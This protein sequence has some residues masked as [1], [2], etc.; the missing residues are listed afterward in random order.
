MF[1][2]LQHFSNK[3]QNIHFNLFLMIQIFFLSFNNIFFFDELLCYLSVEIT[4][5][6]YIKHKNKKQKNLC[7][8]N[9]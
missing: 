7:S 9:E 4:I 1:K 8:A 6:C 2:Y 5:K 3:Y